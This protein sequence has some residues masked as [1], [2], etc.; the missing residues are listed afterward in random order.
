VGE[1]NNLRIA[2]SLGEAAALRTDIKAWRSRW[3]AIDAIGRH[4]TQLDLLCTSVLNLTCE[5]ANRIAAIRSTLDTGTVYEDCRREDIRLLHA[6]RLWRWYADKF[7]Q[8][9][10]SDDIVTQTLLAADEVMWSCWHA[11]FTSLDETLPA[12]PLPYV[13]LLYSASATPRTDP[14]PD[15]RPGRD[16]LLNTM[17][18]RLPIPAVGL[19]PVCCRHPWWLVLSAHEA[20]HHVQFESAG[21]EALTQSKVAAAAYGAIGDVSLSEEWEPWC[22]ELFADACSVLLVGPAAIWAVAELETRTEPELRKSQS[23]SYPPPLIRLAVMRAITAAA[24]IPSAGM[25][26]AGPDAAAD[27]VDQAADRVDGADDRFGK[28]LTAVPAVATALLSLESA[29][30][31]PLRSLTAATAGAYTENGSVPAWTSDLLGPGDPRPRPEL[32]AARFC[33]AG[34]VGAWQRSGGQDGAAERLANRLRAL[35]P[36]CRAPGKRAAR[37]VPDAGQVARQL[38]DD[39]YLA[40]SGRL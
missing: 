10:A 24:R 32:D 37:P 26:S 2:E 20:S 9:W 40:P 16:D 15:L 34:G 39:L 28:L 25:P 33:V 19:P 12:V 5:I 3:D 38:V 11:A 14:P 36:R 17:V 35:L 4:R 7:D 27:P 29:S 6:R 30:G 21:L 18:S 1:R 13:S 8:R 23:G 22:R 31:G